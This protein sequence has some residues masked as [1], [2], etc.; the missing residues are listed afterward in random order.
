MLK[1]KDRISRMPDYKLFF[2]FAKYI[3]P[4]RPKQAAIFALSGISILLELIN[5]YL[6]KLIVDK[7][8]INKNFE[9]FIVYGLIGA[10]IFI[11]NGIIKAAA[12]LLE[13]SMQSR[14]RFDLNKKLFSH[15][16]ALPLSFFKGSAPGEHM[17]TL[18]YDIERT[19]DFIISAP[20]ETVVILG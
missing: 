15:L 4:Y 19:I 18:S 10:A 9:I 16:Q 5:P 11:S 6:G 3:M 2:R 1:Q 17:Y 13:K 7:A 20:R 12:A 8:I 14:V